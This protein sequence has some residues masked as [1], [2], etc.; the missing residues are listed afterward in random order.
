VSFI[1]ATGPRQASAVFS[2]L[3]TLIRIALPLSIL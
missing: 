2:T 3:V 1:L